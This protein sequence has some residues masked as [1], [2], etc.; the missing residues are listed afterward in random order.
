MGHEYLIE[1]ILKDANA[2]A[3]QI[4]ADARQM[5]KSNVE[6]AQKHAVE[7]IADAKATTKKRRE[8]EQEI[9]EGTKLI[10]D[11]LTVLEKQTEIVDKVFDDAFNEIKFRWRVETHPKYEERLTMD[12]LKQSLREEIEPEVVRVLFK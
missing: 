7:M 12:A 8:R 10:A 3:K 11:K 4:L 2:D 9:L 1:K 5:A 6:Y